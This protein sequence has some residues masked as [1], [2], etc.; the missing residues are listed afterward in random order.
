MDITTRRELTTAWTRAGLRRRDLLRLFGAGV[1]LA[2]INAILTAC[3]GTTAATP[4]TGTTATGATSAAK[5]T[6]ASTTASGSAAATNATAATTGSVTTG[7][8][9]RPAAIGSPVAGAAVT[10]NIAT[11]VTLTLPI[12]TTVDITLDPHKAINALIFGNLYEYFYGGLTRYDK[13]AHVIPDLAERWDKSPDGLVYTFHL[14]DGIKFANGK[15]ITPDDFIYSWKRTLDAKAP[16]P[17]INFLEDLKGY[18]EFRTGKAT[19]ISGVR[20]IDDKTIELTLSKPVNYFLSYLSIYTWYVID[21]DLVEKYGDS[22]NTAWTNH[23]PYGT[24]AW[25]VSK[26]DPN[27]GIEL[28]PNENYWG[29]RS[30]SV[31]KINMP[32]IKG[33]TGPTQALN[34]YRGDQ[35]DVYSNFPLSLLDAVEKDFKDQIVDINVGGSASVA[36]SWTKKPFDNMLVRLAFA[37][38]IDRERYDT[39]I[40]RGFYR[41]TEAFEPPTIPDY[42]SPP[43]IKFN[44]DEAKK[45]LVAAGFPNGQGLPPVTLYI[46][47]STA[48]EDVNRYRALADMWNKGLGA[49]V[50]VDTSLTSS[51]IIDKRT[52]EKGFQ[53]ELM[54]WINITETPQLISEVFRTQDIYQKNRFDWGTP[55]PKASYNGVEYDPAA[56]AKTFDALM[57]QADVEQDPKKRNDLYRQGEALVLKNAVYVPYGTFRYRAVAKPKVKGLEFGAYFYTFPFPIEE[58]V[59]VTT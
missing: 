30:P 26:F 38:A 15:P 18:D 50:I 13:D 16:S 39:Q 10:G 28:V 49:N 55:V 14:R 25:K 35:A 53:M 5:P 57:D 34:L 33:P 29:K 44:L 47:S 23:E 32:I 17:A 2:T 20:K 11:G 8:A 27:T 3:G 36:M 1:S 51:Q 41:P 42:T 48:A 56:D 52:A 4:T 21:K 12:V 46:A 6:T 40:W 59:V 24:G 58:K 43:G 22:N 7:S 45:V 31:T 54:G 19:E 9:A 37:M